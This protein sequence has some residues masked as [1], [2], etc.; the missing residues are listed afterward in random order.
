MEVC[1]YL[2]FAA[3]YGLLG[4]FL[5]GVYC[6]GHRLREEPLFHLLTALVIGLA[7]GFVLV[8]GPMATESLTAFHHGAQF[9]LF[10]GAS[11]C[12]APVVVY[13]TIHYWERLLEKLLSPGSTSEPQ[14]RPRTQRESWERVQRCLEALARDPSHPGLHEA[15]GDLYAG[16]GFHDSAAYQY[17]KAAEWTERGYAQGTLLYKAAR[18]LVEKRSDV[19]G[20]L[21]I[22]RRIVRLYPRSYFAAYARRIINQHEAH[23]AAERSRQ[24]TDAHGDGGSSE[25]PYTFLP[26]DIED[27][28]EP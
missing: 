17:R 20:A 26:P 5:S 24:Q 19:P 25:E 27:A 4:A 16:M 10:C 28:G 12:Y 22:L 23:A 3:S 7:A 11:L 14:A 21:G 15:L 9:I 6:L 8:V 18:L 2:L 13:L 1:V